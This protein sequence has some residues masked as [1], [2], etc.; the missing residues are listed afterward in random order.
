MEKPSVTQQAESVTAAGV[1]SSRARA[2]PT[3]GMSRCHA[4]DIGVTQDRDSDSDPVGDR[5][6]HHGRSEPYQRGKVEQKGQR[7]HVNDWLSM[8]AL[9]V[10]AQHNAGQA[11][12]P[13]KL[14][15]ARE[16]LQRTSPGAAECPLCHGQHELS[17][18]KRW[19][20]K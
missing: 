14:R 6:H 3:E 2:L 19:R 18:C 17:Q 4:R 12:D 9:E 13:D 15:L 20:A 5:H 7:K 10:V 1:T 16:V 8:Q 11:I